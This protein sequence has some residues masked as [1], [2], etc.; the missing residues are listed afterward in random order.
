MKDG[1]TF[2]F[3]LKSADTNTDAAIAAGQIVIDGWM[4]T[5]PALPAN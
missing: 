3:K 5:A 1:E 2:D 4:R